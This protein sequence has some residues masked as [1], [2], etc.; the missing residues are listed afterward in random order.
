MSDTSSSSST[1]LHSP[2]PSPRSMR[3]NTN[4]QLSLSNINSRSSSL[5]QQSFPPPTNNTHSSRYPSSQRIHHPRPSNSLLIPHSHDD[6]DRI[7]LEEQLGGISLLSSSRASDS[8]VTN[9]NTGVSYADEDEEEDEEEGSSV[10]IGRAGEVENLSAASGGMSP[11]GGAS[12][13]ATTVFPSPTSTNGHHA[14]AITLRAGLTGAGARA[15][16]GGFDEDRELGQILDHRGESVAGAFSSLKNQPSFKLNNPTPSSRPKLVDAITR[17][18]SPRRP[19]SNTPIASA[20]AYHHRTN[21]NNYTSD[22]KPQESRFEMLAKGVAQTATSSEHIRKPMSELSFHDSREHRSVT[23]LRRGNS[24]GSQSKRNPN[25]SASSKRNSGSKTG[26]QHPS[27]GF[28]DGKSALFLPDVTGLTDGLIDS[29]VRKGKRV[30]QEGL[31][32][33]DPHGSCSFF[34]LIL[35]FSLSLHA[36]FVFCRTRF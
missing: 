4:Q 1:H 24:N 13:S 8:M 27:F 22:V 7:R 17:N 35:P 15:Q 30:V 29:P 18:F 25:K 32:R 10:E 34:C 6:L 21:T 23:S 16:P 19:S 28:G 9:T 12:F 20:N 31:H 11:L 5:L 14:S 36:F 3:R 26:Q 2:S 33:D